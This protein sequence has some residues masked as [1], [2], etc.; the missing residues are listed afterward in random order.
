MAFTSK[1]V[2]AL[3]DQAGQG[4]TEVILQNPETG[5]QK[6]VDVNTGEI[7]DQEFVHPDMLSVFEG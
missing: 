3:E 4:F 7:E 2:A 6:Y 5:Q 1:F